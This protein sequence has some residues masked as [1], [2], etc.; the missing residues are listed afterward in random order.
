MGR[1]LSGSLTRGSR[2]CSSSSSCRSASLEENYVGASD[3]VAKVRA[4]VAGAEHEEILQESDG[5]M[6]AWMLWQLAG[7]EGAAKVFVG[8][9]AEIL[10]NS[11]WQDVDK[12]V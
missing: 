12:N 4:R 3:N 5:Y 2:S 1:R 10:T 9:G 6:T 11:R 8:E 7:D